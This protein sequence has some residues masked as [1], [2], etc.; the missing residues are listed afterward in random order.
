MD[1]LDKLPSFRVASSARRSTSSLEAFQVS[2][3]IDNR[4]VWDNNLAHRIVG[5]VVLVGLTYMGADG[6]VSDQ[7]QFFGTAVSADPRKGILLTLS[8]VRSGEQFNL[9]PDTRGIDAAAPGEY[10][11]RATGDVVVNPDYT[12]EFSITAAS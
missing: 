8:G 5:K 6:A 4:E 1:D 7:Q 11:L 10:R 9:P 3:N 12:V 2:D